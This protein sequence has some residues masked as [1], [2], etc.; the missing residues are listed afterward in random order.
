MREPHPHYGRK[1]KFVAD[2]RP[3]CHHD[4]QVIGVWPDGTARLAV[5]HPDGERQHDNVKIVDAGMEPKPKGT[6]YL[7]E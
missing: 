3:D 6:C 1:V 7:S 2:E 4:A 5:K